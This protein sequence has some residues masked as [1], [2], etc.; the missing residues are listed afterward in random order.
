VG[1][2][3]RSFNFIAYAGLAFVVAILRVCK[4]CLYLAR[5][6]DP[7]STVTGTSV[8]TK[9][10]SDMPSEKSSSSSMKPR[11]VLYHVTSI[12]YHT[13]ATINAVVIM[14]GGTA[15]QL[16][17][18]YRNCFCYAG[19]QDM[20]GTSAINL[21]TNTLEQQWWAKSV[22]LMIGLWSY[23]GIIFACL[24]ALAVRLYISHRIENDIVA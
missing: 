3:C 12:T 1:I 4:D 6:A 8:D 21:S 13:L 15:M 10:D 9:T 22:W 2:G 23:G 14:I 5:G 16:A 18:G 20:S 19:F 7:A 11:R 24:C 17:G